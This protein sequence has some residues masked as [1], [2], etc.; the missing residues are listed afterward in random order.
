MNNKKELIRIF[1]KI[2]EEKGEINYHKNSLD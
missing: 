1:A 2:N